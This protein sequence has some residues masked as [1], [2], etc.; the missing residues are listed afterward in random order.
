MRDRVAAL[1]SVGVDAPAVTAFADALF[2][3]KAAERGLP[4]RLDELA[5]RRA[6]ACVARE[7]VP[8][9]DDGA[10]REYEGRAL[11]AAADEIEARC[12]AAHAAGL[13]VLARRRPPSPPTPR[14]GWRR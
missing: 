12:A 9:A 11:S 7:M 3:V 6:M 5:A 4:D 1:G 10:E 13:R 14:S 2:D 8:G